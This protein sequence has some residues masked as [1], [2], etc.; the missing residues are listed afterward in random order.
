LAPDVMDRIVD[1]QMQLL[2]DRLAQRDIE[3]T[4]TEA[5]RQWLAAEGYDPIYGARP[6]K[7]V[8]QRVVQDQLAGQLLDGSVKAGDQII[9]DQVGGA[10]LVTKAGAG[11]E[12]LVA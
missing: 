4:W 2:A 10:I 11:T 6:L 9:V 5:A 3:V 7:R 1:I 12:D 8:I